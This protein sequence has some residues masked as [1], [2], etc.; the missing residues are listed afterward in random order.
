VP[1]KKISMKESNVNKI[2]DVTFSQYHSANNAEMI[3]FIF[4]TLPIGVVVISRK[5]DIAYKNRHASL[6]LGRFDLPEEI[7][8]LSRKIFDAFDRKKFHELFPGEITITKKFEGSPSN[9]MFKFAA[10]VN[11]I[12]FIVLFIIEDK[13]SNKL[14]LNEIR[15]QYRLTRRETDIL[16]RVLDGLKNIEISRDLEIVEQTVKDHLSNIYMKIGAENRFDL[17]R[18]LLSSSCI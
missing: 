9:W 12:P 16:R 10:P 11:A 13:I 1:G 5:I 8:S 3:D 4:E 18:S 15:Q 7:A 6:F 14:N 2:Q 17:I